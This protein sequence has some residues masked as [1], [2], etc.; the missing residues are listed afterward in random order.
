MQRSPRWAP[1]MMSRLLL[2][3]RRLERAD[4]YTNVGPSAS[5]LGSAVCRRSKIL[6]PRNVEHPSKTGSPK[7]Y[8]SAWQ[9]LLGPGEE[10]KGHE[11]GVTEHGGEAQQRMQK[12]RSRTTD[13]YSRATRDR[14]G[15]RTST[16]SSHGLRSA[17]LLGRGRGKHVVAWDE[18]VETGCAVDVGPLLLRGPLFATAS[19]ASTQR[20]SMVPTITGVQPN[21]A[22]FHSTRANGSFFPNLGVHP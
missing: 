15:S 17:S 1:A 14:A 10:A 12:R 18:G 16:T 6:E 7:P 11:R 5:A 20:G 2:D 8:L 21:S 3:E 22:P 9:T 19:G 4:L 13:A